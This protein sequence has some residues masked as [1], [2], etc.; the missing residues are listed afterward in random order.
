M[1]TH[2]C[3]ARLL[4]GWKPIPFIA[5]DNSNKMRLLFCIYL[6]RFV[7]FCL[8]FFASF[9][10]WL[11]SFFLGLYNFLGNLYRKK[12][13]KPTNDSTDVVIKAFN[14]SISSTFLPGLNRPPTN[15]TVCI[16]TCTNQMDFQKLNVKKEMIYGLTSFRSR[17]NIMYV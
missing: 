5:H 17:N 8:I 11:R 2:V 15:R 9:V 1:Y 7:F 16:D 14:S 4:C 6:F 10:G 3:N 12:M 13:F